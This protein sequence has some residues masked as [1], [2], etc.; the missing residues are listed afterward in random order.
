MNTIAI[1]GRV[2]NDPELKHI[3]A[4]NTALLEFSVANETGYGDYSKTH[5]FRV[6]IWG[7]RAEGLANH[8]YKGKPVNITGVM[9]QDRYEDSNGNKRQA[10][11]LICNEF[12]FH[13]AEPKNAPQQG[14]QPQ[15][16][17]GSYQQPQ[18]GGGFPKPAAPQQ[19]DDDIPF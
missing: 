8:I 7:K 15:G 10:W 14:S 6:K 11:S 16:T 1:D 12:N 9:E 18:Q 19:F 2:A 13:M 17:G 3:G 4:K 5:F